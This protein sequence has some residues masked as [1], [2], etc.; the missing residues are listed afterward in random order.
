MMII[1]QHHSNGPARVA[2]LVT[3]GRTRSLIDAL[4]N[5]EEKRNVEQLRLAVENLNAALAGQ[6]RSS[7]IMAELSAPQALQ[8]FVRHP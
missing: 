8:C 3:Q 4:G 2:I 1:P 7:D 6:G 5:Q